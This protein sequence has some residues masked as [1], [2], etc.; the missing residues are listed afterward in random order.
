MREAAH[1]NRLVQQV[2]ARPGQRVL[3]LGCGT[4]T[5]SLLLKRTYPDTEILGLDADEDVLSMVLST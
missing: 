2:A 4:A 5:L 3:D 1:K